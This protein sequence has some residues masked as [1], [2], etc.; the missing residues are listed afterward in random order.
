ML[1]FDVC[2]KP[3]FERLAVWMQEARGHGAPT[4]MCY[5]VSVRLSP[6]SPAHR[7]VKPC[8]E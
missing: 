6:A 1:V 4:G 5:V 7:P 8:C 2:S 3:S